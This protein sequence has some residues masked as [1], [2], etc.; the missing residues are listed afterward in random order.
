MKTCSKCKVEKS[1]TEF[2]RKGPGHQP[3]CK[4]CHSEYRKEH[5]ERNK[6]KVR[7]QV[8]ERRSDLREWLKDLKKDLKCSQCGEDHIACLDFH[9]LDPTEKD[10]SIAEAPSRGWSQTRALEEMKK[11]VVL[12]SNC[13]R[14]LHWSERIG[15]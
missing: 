15:R 9:H 5:Y 7:Q 1:L 11:C 10:L 2:S 8:Y 13:H 3:Y 6:K 4:L 14:K 12:C